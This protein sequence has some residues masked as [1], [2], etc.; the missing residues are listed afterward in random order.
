[1]SFK[2]NS[3]LAS[4]R[5]L[6]SSW[7]LGTGSR[8]PARAGYTQS[9]P[10]ATMN[11]VLDQWWSEYVMVRLKESTRESYAPLLHRIRQSFGHMDP[12]AIGPA[13]ADRYR[14]WRAQ[15]SKA[16]AKKEYS[17][18]SSTLTFAADRDYIP[19]NPLKGQASR[20][21]FERHRDCNRVPTQA[22]LDAFCE[23]NPGMQGFVE[24]KQLTGLKQ[25]RL[26]SINLTDHWDGA[27]LHL[28]GRR[29]DKE[30]A[31]SSAELTAVIEK[32]L[33]G[34]LPV[35]PLFLNTQGKR[36]KGS[37]FRSAWRRAMI[38]FEKAGGTKF[39]EQDIA[40]AADLKVAR[41]VKPAQP[42]VAAEAPPAAAPEAEAGPEV[43]ASAEER[44][45]AEESIAVRVRNVKFAQSMMMPPAVQ[46]PRSQLRASPS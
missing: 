39:S 46:E 15:E 43:P 33:D 45:S 35:G 24:L 22:E 29:L 10:T 42:E 41:L 17:I 13:H 5:K 44:M 31:E 6:A 20:A 1:V 16:T 28:P 8:A 18:L 9:R 27:T 7:K 19:Y 11:D 3:L 40:R 26:L 38:R 2:I 23:V 12:G 32:I 4:T 21:D 30:F 34:R 37:S 36:V 25:D 14:D